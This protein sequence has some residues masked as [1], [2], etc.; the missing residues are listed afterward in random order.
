MTRGALGVSVEENKPVHGRAIEQHAEH[1]RAALD[2]GL[3]TNQIVA[4]NRVI[5]RAAAS[6]AAACRDAML[7]VLAEIDSE[8]ERALQLAAAARSL[9]PVLKEVLAE[10]LDAHMNELVKQQ[11]S[12][13]LL[14]SGSRVAVQPVA[15]G[16]VDATGFTR[17]GQTSPPQ[18]LA[19]LAEVLEQ[20]ADDA[21]E[22]EVQLVK[23]IGDALMLASPSAD[24]IVAS[25]LAL[26]HTAAEH[27]SDSPALHA[28]AA[29]GPAMAR[30]GDW[31]GRSVNLASRLSDL[32]EPGTCLID[33]DLLSM[34]SWRRGW[35]DLGRQHVDGFDLPIHTYAMSPCE[36]RS[37]S[38]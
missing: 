32:A 17:L 23:T 6:V 2:A 9:V 28:G 13:A 31:Y 21:L 4:L 7:P 11:A 26:L 14:S 37:S 8:S 24:A 38:S 10:A 12:A 16:F 5:G 33:H 30:A 22:P 18:K 19:G 27:R 15:V 35:R 20:L 3:P 34:L 29:W 36:T 1:L 25:I